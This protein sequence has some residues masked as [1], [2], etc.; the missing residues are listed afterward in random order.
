MYSGSIES[1]CKF[2]DGTITICEGTL[3]SLDNKGFI[4]ANIGSFTNLYAHDLFV[5]DDM[6]VN[7]N[8]TYLNTSQTA[9]E[10]ELISLGAT[11]GRSV[12]SLSTNRTVIYC[13]TD[14]PNTYSSSSYALLMQDNGS[15][16]II[17]ISSSSNNQ[18]NLSSA[19]NANTQFVSLISTETIADGSGLE[20]LA[21]NNGNLRNKKFHYVHD[22]SNPS[23]EIKSDNSALDLRLTNLSANNSVSYYS[24]QDKDNLGNNKHKKL[25]TS[26]GLYLNTTDTGTITGSSDKSAIYLSK[27]GGK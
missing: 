27:N 17:Q 8:T 23:M 2:T 11:D 12:A 26:D 19:A 14:V 16:E 7:G 3:S 9:F 4:E 13:E 24:V 20:I 15:K 10:D 6:V 18:I 1:T 22:N 21:H 5:A 25:L